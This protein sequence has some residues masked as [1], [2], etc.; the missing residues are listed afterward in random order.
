LLIATESI[1]RTVEGRE[2]A[3][4]CSLWAERPQSLIVFERIDYS[5]VD[6]VRRHIEA[7]AGGGFSP[8][9]WRAQKNRW[10]DGELL[11]RVCAI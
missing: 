4:T 7:T 8:Y 9:T 3:G 2:G 11:L 5:A 10:K 6:G 1:V